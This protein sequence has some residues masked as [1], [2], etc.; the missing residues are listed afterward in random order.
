MTGSA[1]VTL[2]FFP[3][4]DVRRFTFDARSAPFTRP[5]PDRP[6]G[7]PMDATGTVR[8]SHYVAAANLTVTFEAAV[9]CMITSP[10]YAG[11]T[12]IVTR[13]DGPVADWVGT[14]VGFSIQDGG[15]GGQGDRLGYTWS[16]SGVQD[17]NGTWGQPKIGTCLTIAPFA[18]VTRGDFTVRHTELKPD[19]PTGLKPDPHTEL[20][21][22]PQPAG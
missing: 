3:D 16:M 22:D 11:L 15:R 5:V 18:P 12:A 17:E 8:V 7:N 2:P 6:Q 14:R 19:P 1:E 4:Q 9:D 21:P 10:G 20:K 13:A